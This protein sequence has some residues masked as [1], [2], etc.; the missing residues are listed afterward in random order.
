[1]TATT[2]STILNK[3]SDDLAANDRTMEHIVMN[4]EEA[5]YLYDIVIK[6]I[7]Q[8]DAVIFERDALIAERDALLIKAK[9]MSGSDQPP[10]RPPPSVPFR[11][12]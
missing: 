7:I 11:K 5:Q 10:P 1:M 2:V 6:I 12:G 8:R 9:I 3:I 4:R